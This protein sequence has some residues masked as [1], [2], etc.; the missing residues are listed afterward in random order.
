MQV[1]ERIKMVLMLL[2]FWEEGTFSMVL[3]MSASATTIAMPWSSS[4]ASSQFSAASANCS[5]MLPLL[6][7]PLST[8]ML[9]SSG[10]AEPTWSWN[11]WS[12][13]LHLGFT[14]LGD[15]TELWRLKCVEDRVIEPLWR[16]GY[17]GDLGD[18][19][20]IWIVQTEL[21]WNSGGEVN[22]GEY[23]GDCGD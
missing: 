14:Q 9:R 15:W 7:F 12:V 19:T 10:S 16:W 18:C 13:H 22:C 17:F 1:W 5:F 6:Y 4:S 8:S 21:D 23:C 3:S 11:Q 2:S 20:A